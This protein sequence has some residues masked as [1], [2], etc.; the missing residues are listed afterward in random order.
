MG[1]APVDRQGILWAISVAAAIC[2]TA[3]RLSNSGYRLGLRPTA[4]CRPDSIF[5]YRGSPHKNGTEYIRGTASSPVIGN[6]I[7]SIR[8]I[9]KR[10]FGIGGA[11]QSFFIRHGQRARLCRGTERLRLKMQRILPEGHLAISDREGRIANRFV[12]SDLGENFAHLRR[13]RPIPG[14]YILFEV[15]SMLSYLSRIQVIH[16]QADLPRRLGPALPPAIGGFN[17]D[18][19]NKLLRQRAYLGFQRN[20]N[21]YAQADHEHDCAEERH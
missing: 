8:L 19:I 15:G 9:K 11:G 7:R 2:G 3:R 21:E 13:V 18:S 4:R 20:C 16:G 14:N 6:E 12:F 5:S 10:S 1:P 17:S